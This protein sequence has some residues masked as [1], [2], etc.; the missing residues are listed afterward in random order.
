MLKQLCVLTFAILILINLPFTSAAPLKLKTDSNLNANSCIA[1]HST[2]F[3]PTELGN[4]YLEWHF[5]AHK[6]KGVSCDQCHGGNPKAMGKEKSHEGMLPAQELT[7]KINQWNQPETC[8]KCHRSTVKAF[9]ES[10][11]YQRLKSSE[12][13]PSCATCHG[14]MGASVIY[15]PSEIANLCASC[16]STINGVSP[17]RL[18]ISKRAR[19]VMESLQ[20]TDYLVSWANLLLMRAKER[21]Q[22][23]S[24]EQEEM[25]TINSAMKAALDEWHSFDLN[26]VGDRYDV[27]FDQARILKE[28]LA[29]KN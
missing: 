7:S 6:D 11:H 29:K 13:G 21:K 25:K 2:T 12:T 18:D 10:K 19:S 23:V 14:H 27:I 15:S 16:H 22:S 17:T 26:S 28:R 3:S 4:K 8:G 9:V 20:R 24:A 5:S 1:C